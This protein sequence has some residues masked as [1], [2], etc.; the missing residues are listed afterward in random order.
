L[1]ISGRGASIAIVENGRIKLL[2]DYY[3][4]LSFF[5]KP[6]VLL[7]ELLPFLHG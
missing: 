1:P 5:P 6:S 4:S 7:A 3:D 2:T